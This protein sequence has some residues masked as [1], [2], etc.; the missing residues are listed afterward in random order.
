VRDAQHTHLAWIRTPR[1]RGGLGTSTRIPLVADTGKTISRVSAAHLKR[2]ACA[3]VSRCRLQDYGVLVEDP[4]DGMFGAALRLAAQG[5]SQPAFSAQSEG[6]AIA[7]R[8]LCH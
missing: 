6:P 2:A 4:A 7:Q 3:S 5:S 8:P 1:E